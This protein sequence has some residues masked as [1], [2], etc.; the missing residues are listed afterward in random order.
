M[1]IIYIFF[2][3]DTTDI[4]Y[5]LSRKILFVFIESRISALTLSLRFY[6]RILDFLLFM[7]KKKI[8]GIGRKVTSA[9]TYYISR[10]FDTTRCQK[11]CFYKI[12]VW[13]S[14]GLSP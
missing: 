6:E 7:I 2:I 4:C 12:L 1:K 14:V 5:F 11:T 8:I 10:L 9:R 3:A 13:Q